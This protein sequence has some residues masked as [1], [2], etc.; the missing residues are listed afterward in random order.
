MYIFFELFDCLGSI[1]SSMGG[2]KKKHLKPGHSLLEETT[3]HVS[4]DEENDVLQC[5]IAL[6]KE[7][8]SPASDSLGQVWEII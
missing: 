8:I 1:Y 3:N 6:L 2:P 7:D 4:L 5:K